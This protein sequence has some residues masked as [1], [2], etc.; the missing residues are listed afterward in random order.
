[1]NRLLRTAGLTL[2]ALTV[3]MVVSGQLSARPAISVSLHVEDAQVK[4]DKP[5]KAR[6]GRLVELRR[7]P[8]QKAGVLA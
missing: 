4:L 6:V 3:A 2:S 5:A 8:V 7:N 1:M